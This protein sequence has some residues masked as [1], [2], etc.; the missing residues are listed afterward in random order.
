MWHEKGD[1]I[2]NWTIADGGHHV[3]PNAEVAVNYRRA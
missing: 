3:V 2:A 1:M